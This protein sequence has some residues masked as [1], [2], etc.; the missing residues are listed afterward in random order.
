MFHP[1]F[2]PEVSRAILAFLPTEVYRACSHQCA[3]KRTELT[4]AVVSGVNGVAALPLY[5]SHIFSDSPNLGWHDVGTV[6]F[7]PGDKYD[8]SLDSLNQNMIDFDHSEVMRVS[9]GFVVY[10]NLVLKVHEGTQAYNKGVEADWHIKHINGED[11]SVGRLKQAM[12]GSQAYTLV[13]EKPNCA[14]VHCALCRDVDNFN[15]GTDDPDTAEHH[16]C[17]QTIRN[18]EIGTTWSHGTRLYQSWY[19]LVP[20]GAGSNWCSA[21]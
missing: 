18:V 20:A 15:A 4:F 10:E 7:S 11:F 9:S 6:H 13:F 17:Y 2:L 21:A 3:G 14:K 19:Q 8:E 5:Q 12:D 16:G 1:E